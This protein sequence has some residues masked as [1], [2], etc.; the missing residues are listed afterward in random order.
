[1]S[2]LQLPESYFKLQAKGTMSEIDTNLYVTNNEYIK[3]FGSVDYGKSPFV[4]LTI[5]SPKV[6]LNNVLKIAKAYLDTIH[7]KNDID[8]M[9]ASGYLLSNAHLKTDFT[10][11]NSMVK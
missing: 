1:M 6:Y 4:D 9:T 8:R 5:K 3:L 11:I 10:D 2:G 7:I